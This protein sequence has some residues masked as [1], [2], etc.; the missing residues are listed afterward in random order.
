M[1][2][3]WYGRSDGSMDEAGIV[4]CGDRSTGGDNF[5][6]ECGATN[7]NQ[8]EVRDRHCSEAAVLTTL[9]QWFCDTK[10]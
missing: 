7:S 4:V 8:W 5:G 9:C 1:N 10:L 3:V 6:G 2:A